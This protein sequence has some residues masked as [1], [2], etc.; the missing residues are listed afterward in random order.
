VVVTIRP[1]GPDAAPGGYASGNGYGAS[2]GYGAAFP[3]DGGPEG[4]I[5][6]P[7]A[8]PASTV[9]R[10]RPVPEARVVALSPAS[11]PRAGKWEF[12]AYGEQPRRTGR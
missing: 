7:R 6:M 12:P 4:P 8:D 1:A 5:P 9:P 3:Y 11:A 2:A 10:L